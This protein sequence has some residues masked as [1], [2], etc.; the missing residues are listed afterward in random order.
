MEYLQMPRTIQVRTI[1]WALADVLTGNVLHLCNA[2]MP[3]GMAVTLADLEAAEVS[4]AMTW[5]TPTAVVY[6]AE[7]VSD[8]TT[9]LQL[10]IWAED[11]HFRYED[12]DGTDDPVQVGGYYIV[13][14]SYNLVGYVKFAESKRMEMDYDGVVCEPIVPFK[15]QAA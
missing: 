2:S 15:P 11:V 13:D 3:S 10:N 7:P 14:A 6:V 8:P 5:Y 12:G 4:D 1:T 9:A